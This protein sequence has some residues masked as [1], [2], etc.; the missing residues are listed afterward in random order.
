[1]VIT[2]PPE[3][4]SVGRPPDIHLEERVFA[5]TLKVYGDYGWSAT[6]LSRIATEGGVGKSTLYTRWGTKGKLLQSAFTSILDREPPSS[7]V[8][9][10]EWFI[11]DGEFRLRSYLGPYRN[12]VL[13][14]ALE[15]SISSDPDLQKIRQELYVTPLQN[16]MSS[17]RRLR[18]EGF[19][20]ADTSIVRMAD[21]IEGSIYNR[22]M[23]VPSDQVPKVLENCHEYVSIIVD[24]Q[25]RLAQV[26][27]DLLLSQQEG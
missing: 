11:A 2:N 9:V 19:I 14:L 10:R 8:S 7:R 17:L 22:A 16:A 15:F 3:P 27:G 24:Q 1:M 6:N 12:A 23:W 26:S 13:R 5:A 4:R 18:S 21:A 25:L 20:P